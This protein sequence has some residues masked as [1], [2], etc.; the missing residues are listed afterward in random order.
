[1]ITRVAFAGP[2]P[3]QIDLTA[4]SGRLLVELY[5]GLPASRIRFRI[6]FPNAE[7]P[8]DVVLDPSQAIPNHRHWVLVFKPGASSVK[9]VPSIDTVTGLFDNSTRSIVDMIQ[10]NGK[11]SKMGWDKYNR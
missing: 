8:E 5:C 3:V 9:S 10:D 6:R 11:Y 4:G 7:T 2:G 1:M